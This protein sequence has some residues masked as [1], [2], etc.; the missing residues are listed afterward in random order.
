MS[1]TRKTMTAR[2]FGVTL[3]YKTSGNYSVAGVIE[4]RAGDGSISRRIAAVGNSWSSVETRAR[5]AL[6]LAGHVNYETGVMVVSL[7]EE[8]A[9]VLEDY[10]GSRVFTVVQGFRPGEGWVTLNYHPGASLLRRLAREGYTSVSCSKGTRPPA[11]FE[12][13]E[14][15]KSLNARKQA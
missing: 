10:F 15:I 11:D 12:M 3:E 14:V 5:R 6:R 9:P 13:T 1:G 7:V 2:A 8:T 4:Y